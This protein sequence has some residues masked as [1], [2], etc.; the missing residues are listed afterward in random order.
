M[1][2]AEVAR[3]QRRSVD[4]DELRD[5]IQAV[6]QRSHLPAQDIGAAVIA[7]VKEQR[8]CVVQFGNFLAVKIDDDLAIRKLTDEQISG[9][10]PS[11]E[12]PKSGTGCDWSLV[13]GS[14]RPRLVV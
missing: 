11:G 1:P 14:S 3:R 8:R 5:I 6:D 4:A 12:T 9:L 10:H 2:P 7:A 13:R